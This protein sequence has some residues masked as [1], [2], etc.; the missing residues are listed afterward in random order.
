[1][2]VDAA[3]VA[4]QEVASDRATVDSDG[5]RASTAHLAIDRRAAVPVL[6]VVAS[7]PLMLTFPANSPSDAF[8]IDCSVDCGDCG[9][10]PR[11]FQARGAC[12]NGGSCSCNYAN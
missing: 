5:E 2:A 6:A 8:F 4:E 11:I 7:Q 10:T 1:M 12:G 3:G 9:C